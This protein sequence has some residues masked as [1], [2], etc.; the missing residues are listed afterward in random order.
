MFFGTP[1]VRCRHSG[2]SFPAVPGPA[3]QARLTFPSSLAACGSDTGHWSLVMTLLNTTQWPQMVITRQAI[4]E[5]LTLSIFKHYNRRYLYWI[6]S[7]FEPE[8]RQNTLNCCCW[9]HR[10]SS[11][12]YWASCTRDTWPTSPPGH[13]SDLTTRTCPPETLFIWS[14]LPTT[15]NLERRIVWKKISKSEAIID[16]QKFDWDWG[17]VQNILSAK[18]F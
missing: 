2:A 17:I 6:I 4:R 16:R 10:D 1:C 14:A 9:G 3:L 7:Q 13:V 18:S 12:R 8:C 5:I 15:L 11:S